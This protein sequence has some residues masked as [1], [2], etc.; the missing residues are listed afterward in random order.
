MQTQS[1]LRLTL[2]GN[3][4]QLGVRVTCSYKVLMSAWPGVLLMHTLSRLY[5]PGCTIHTH[6]EVLNKAVNGQLQ[7]CSTVK[8]IHI[9]DIFAKKF[10]KVQDFLKTYKYVQICANMCKYVQG[11]KI[12]H[13]LILFY[14][15]G[16]ACC[17]H[18]IPKNATCTIN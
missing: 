13:F 15:R 5:T 6:H 3:A 18:K 9:F 2:T 12:L 14:R 17:T 7:P 4:L 1:T 16:Q 10:K 8:N 11:K